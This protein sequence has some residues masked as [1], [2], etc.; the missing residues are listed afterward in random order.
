MIKEL[1]EVEE[2]SKRIFRLL[3]RDFG[4][5]NE[6]INKKVTNISSIL[7]VLKKEK[8]DIDKELDLSKKFYSDIE[9]HNLPHSSKEIKV[10]RE[11][12]KGLEQRKKL[13]DHGIKSK[14]NL[15]SVVRQ[16]RSIISKL[17]RLEK[18]EVKEV[19]KTEKT[20]DGGKGSKISTTMKGIMLIVVIALAL[21]FFLSRG[22]KEVT[23]SDDQPG[24]ILTKDGLD[25]IALQTL[26]RYEAGELS[27]EE[28]IEKVRSAYEKEGLSRDVAT[29]EATEVVE[30]MIS[31][32]LE[33]G[34]QSREA[35]ERMIALE[36]EA[37]RQSR[38]AIERRIISDEEIIKQSEEAIRRLNS[39]EE[40]AAKQSEEAVNR[41][42]AVEAEF[43]RQ[44]KEAVERLQNR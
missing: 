43:D 24:D 26:S 15:R 9:K 16:D 44:S 33:A 27:K 30:R 39:L 36:E 28:A 34:R 35:V 38:E 4:F 14:L 41:V 3:R 21:F 13:I 1:K 8:V 32:E 12:Y 19:K 5:N 10:L 29:K 6:I 37:A 42:K 18:E 2:I 40:E 23:D 25:Q 31:Y 22:G 20:L 17:I 11:I 7:R